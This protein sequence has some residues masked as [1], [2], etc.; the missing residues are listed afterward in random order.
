ERRQ[1]QRLEER[2]AAMIGVLRHEDNAAQ[3]LRLTLGLGK[4]NHRTACLAHER[5]SDIA[6]KWAQNHFLLQRASCQEIDFIRTGGCEDRR[7]RVLTLLVM[8]RGI[9]RQSKLKKS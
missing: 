2:G 6:Q 5:A 4:K 7:C 1:A 3:R 8:N 9:F